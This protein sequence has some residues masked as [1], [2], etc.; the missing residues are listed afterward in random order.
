M[1]SLGAVKR[2]RCNGGGILSEETECFGLNITEGEMGIT[3]L[4]NKQKTEYAHQ[5]KTKPSV[6]LE[7]KVFYLGDITR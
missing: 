2:Y 1:A 4:Q 7:R 3:G 5:V 6:R